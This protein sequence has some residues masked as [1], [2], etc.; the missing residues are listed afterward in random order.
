M[1]VS[2]SHTRPRVALHISHLG[3]VWDMSVS[4]HMRSLLSMPS[5]FYYLFLAFLLNRIR[6]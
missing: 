1:V 6:M 5:L 4:I 2:G 3:S